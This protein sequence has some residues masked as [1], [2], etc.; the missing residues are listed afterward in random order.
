MA[1]CSA[2]KQTMKAATRADNKH[3]Q[4]PF[5]TEMGANVCCII[6]V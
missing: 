4:P 1:L 2:W 6:H 5:T 3:N